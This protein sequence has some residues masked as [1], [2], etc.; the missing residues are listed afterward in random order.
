MQIRSTPFSR[1]RLFAATAVCLVAIPLYAQSSKGAITGNVVDAAGAKIPGSTVT[2]LSPATGTSVTVTTNGDGIYRFE[3][4]TPGDYVVQVS[5]PGFVK[6]EQ[7]AT[8]V[9]GSNV[10]RD[11][12]LRPGSSETVEVEANRAAELQTEDAV[13]GGTIPAM[14]LA[15]IP[16]SGQNSLNL[17]LTI[18]G[19]AKTNT[20][21][22]D[23]GGVG[24]VNGARGRSNNFLIDGLQNNDISVAGPQFTITNNDELQEVNFQTSN[25]TAEYGRAGGAVVNQVTKSGTNAVHGTVATVYRSEVLNASTN[26]QRINSNYGTSLTQVL[27]PKFKENIPAFTI[28]GPVY[29]PHIYNGHDK[30]FFFGAGQWDR[31]S[32]NNAGATFIVPTANGYATLAPLA[33]SCPNVANYLTSLGA[34]RGTS[35]T[36]AQISIAVPTN[37]ASTTCDGT[38]RTGQVVEVSNYVRPASE[39]SLDNNHLIRIDEIASDKQT[40]MFRWL[41]DDTQDNIGGTVGI[42]PNF[43][44]PFTGRTMGANFN[45]TYTITPAVLNEFRFG[46][47]RNKYTFF[48]KP[49]IADQLPAYTV[50]GI[51]SLNLSSTFPQG[52]ISNNFQYQDAVSYS[53]GRHA[54]KFGVEFLR[55]LATQQAPYNSRGIYTYNQTPVTAAAGVGTAITAL[56]NY[57]DNDAGPNGTAA[58]SIGSGRYHPNLFTWTMYAQDVWKATPDLTLTYGVRYENFGQP[59]NIFKYP[60]FVGTGDADI[61]NTSRVNN[62]NNNFGPTFGFSFNP[63]AR[64]HGPFSGSTVIRG[65]YQVTY[66][67]QFNNILSNLVAGVPNTV[68]NA[69]VVSTTSATTPRGYTNLTAF[70]FTASV[71]TPYTAEASKVTKNLRNPYYHH[72]SLGFQQEMAGKTVLDVAYVGTLGRQL[73]FTNIYNPALPNATFTSTGTIATTNYG[74][75]TLRLFPNRGSISIRDQGMTSSYHALQV[76]VRRRTQQTRFGGYSFSSSYTYSKTLDTIG[77]IFATYGSGTATP[78]RSQSIAGPLGYIDHGPADTDLRHISTTLIQ[79]QLPGVKN[80]F[81]NEFVGG[82]TLSPILY[83]TSGQPYTVLNGADRDLD[84]AL[85]SDRPDIGNI[86]APKNTRG[87]VTA[88]VAGGS[89]LATSV[90]GSGLYNGNATISATNPIS[91]NCV[92]RTDVHFVQ[93]TSYSPTSPFMESRNSNLTTRYLDLDLNVLKKFSITERFRAELRGEFFNVTNN[94]NFTTPSEPANV[95]TNNG[96]NFQNFVGTSTST[97]GAGRT[98]RVG[99]KILF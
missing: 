11:F 31:F 1:A 90:C 75:Q 55:Q 70:P 28:G 65:G 42:N 69:T 40:M 23:T 20:G 36:P 54:M 10:G 12:T 62:D 18:P 92:N 34:I 17:M 77:D 14:A 58:I 2:L 30:T 49:G 16:I 19:V 76:Q 37:L 50:S 53:R 8:V 82:W 33:A 96:V 35:G 21:S 3:G 74:T 41:Y 89:V 95:S 85:T 64:D 43:D 29:I 88:T 24:S 73:Y 51:T 6:S 71:V 98:L 66:D 60:A 22:N 67:T 45:H 48:N 4:L 97:N 39:I 26:A 63:H 57:I 47:V 9:V 78:S 25:F 68:G 72:F 5:Q 83:L 87:L 13:R 56:A 44:V 81:A 15:E 84:G 86:N 80:R 93:V 99:A 32:A 61:T 46:F 27:K 52:R 38:A 94:A 59:A 7:Q 79:W 91:S